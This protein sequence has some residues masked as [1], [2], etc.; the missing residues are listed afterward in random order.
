LKKDETKKEEGQQPQIPPPVIQKR[1]LRAVINNLSFPSPTKDNP[2][3]S[4]SKL[5]DGEVE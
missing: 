5:E 4:T 3:A 1:D 2:L